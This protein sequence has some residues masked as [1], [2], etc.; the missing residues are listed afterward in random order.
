MDV[1]PSDKVLLAVSGGVDSVVLAWLFK[2]CGLTFGIAHCNFKLRGIESD[3]DE[4]FVNELAHELK[5]DFFGRSFDTGNFAQERGISIQMAARELRYAW[6][7]EVSDKH[8][9]NLIATAHHNNDHT[10]T[11][12]MNITRSTGLAGLQGIKSRKGNIIRPLLFF[13]RQQIEEY[14]QSRQLHFR[15]DSS[16][17]E[18]KYFRN[19]IRHK[20]IPALKEINPS[21]DQAIVSLSGI[22]EKTQQLMSYLIRKEFDPYV[23]FSGQ[24]CLIKITSLLEAPAREL[25]LWEYLNAFGFTHDVILEISESL[26]KQPGKLFYSSGYL[27][28]IDRDQLIVEPLKGKPSEGEIIIDRN[29]DE[30]KVENGKFIFSIHQLAEKDNFK[31]E[32]NE[33]ILD[34]FQMTYPLKLRHPQDGDYFFPFGMKGKKKLNDF[35]TDKKL[36]LTEKKKIWLLCN[37]DGVICWVVGMRSDNRFRVNSSSDK[38]LSIKFVPNPD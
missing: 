18:T 5:V 21:F 36:P 35:L 22:A 1:N 31:T 30:V 6:F 28:L 9:Y 16:N 20:V 23:V 34:F 10:E 11:V 4:R 24:R 19:K 14:A 17:A 13:T 7:K 27:C 3:Q 26:Q 29:V 37:S 32:P 15:E 38:M 33:V 12:L 2:E 25:V 8:G